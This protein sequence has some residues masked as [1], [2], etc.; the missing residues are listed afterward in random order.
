MPSI[1]EAAEFAL[2]NADLL[3]KSQQAACY[4]CLS[5]FPVEEIG[6]FRAEEEGAA[7]AYCPVCGVDAVLGDQTGY[8]FT[9]NQLRELGEYWFGKMPNAV[10]SD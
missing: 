2:H 1:Q 10:C 3:H 5:L 4:H 6:D 7:T 8:V 9:D